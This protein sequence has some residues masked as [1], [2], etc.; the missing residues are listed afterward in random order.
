MAGRSI[1][2][3]RCVRCPQGAVL[4]FRGHWLQSSPE[5]LLDFPGFSGALRDSPELSEAL[6]YSLQ[7]P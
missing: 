7:L 5:L 6:R 2:A 4:N 1:A 3:P